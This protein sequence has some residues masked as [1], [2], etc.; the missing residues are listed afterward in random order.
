VNSAGIGHRTGHR[1]GRGGLSPVGQA[2][3]REYYAGE[4]G[5]EFPE[6]RAVD[7][8]GHSLGQFS[9]LVEH[10]LCSPFLIGDSLPLFRALRPMPNFFSAARRVTD[11]AILLVSSSNF[12]VHNFPSFVRLLLESVSDS[13]DSRKMYF[14]MK[15]MGR[16]SSESSSGSERYQ[17]LA[18]M[19]CHSSWAS[20]RS[21]PSETGTNWDLV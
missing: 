9:Y 12:V 16:V 1:P 5:G 7:G 18:P 13:R 17:G 15:T 4:V 11:W 21:L 10:N 3:G 20:R 2:D 6:G 14:P 8:L 19:C